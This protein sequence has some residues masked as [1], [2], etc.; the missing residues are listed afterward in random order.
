[1][2]L[3]IIGLGRM[4]AGIAGR[5]GEKG[6][7]VVGF[8]SDP[9]MCDRL[10]DKGLETA[11]SITQLIDS[12]DEPRAIWLMVPAGPTVRSRRMWGLN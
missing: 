4:G 11:S 1:M 12:L 2:Q 8:D 5:L 7:E 10:A 9:E 3:G 6:H